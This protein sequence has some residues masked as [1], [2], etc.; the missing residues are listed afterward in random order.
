[1][2]AEQPTPQPAPV[3]Y[4]AV[5]GFP[6]YRIGNDGSVWTCKVK[7]GNDRSPGRTGPWRR[8]VLHRDRAGYP[9]VNLDRDGRNHSRLIHRLVLESFVGPRPNGLEACH[10]PDPDKWNNH[11]AN[12]R[13]DTHGENARDRYRD[14]PPV[15]EKR[16]CRCHQTKS[17]SDFYG[18]RRASDGLQPE[19][20]ACH[21]ARRKERIRVKTS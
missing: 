15:T 18:D 12:L 14:R 5:P 10:Y 13:W 9:R 20:R 4:R 19:C 11:L 1:M 8:L 7:G 21:S 16:C 17:V 6:G 3:E 2:A